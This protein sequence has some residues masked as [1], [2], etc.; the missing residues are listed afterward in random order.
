MAAE[1]RRVD[2]ELAFVLH[3]QPYRETSSIVDIFSRGFGRVALVAR[4]ARRPRSQ[5]RG[6]LM[7]FQPLEL[8]WVGQGELA[9]L[10]RAEWVGGQP[11]LG[12]IA[13]LYGYYLNELLMRLLPRE[14]A[15]PALFDAYQR[16]L[17]ILCAGNHDSALLRRFECVLLREIGYAPL[18]DHD[19]DS[20]EALS[21]ER[22]YAY[23]PERGP[24]LVHETTPAGL[25]IPGRCLL[26]MAAD[27]YSAPETLR[28][29]KSLMRMLIAHHLD[30]QEL[31]SRRV[32]VE[33]NEL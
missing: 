28:H 9:N 24:V 26:A 1:R 4:G 11:L 27:D 8:G 18:F 33:L 17:A 20:G 14:D 21:A 23:Q 31:R 6:L 15:H 29:S 30:G 12:G 2:G 22:M 10:S 16:T 5:L 3:S 32:F 25:P 7:E 13:L 19:A